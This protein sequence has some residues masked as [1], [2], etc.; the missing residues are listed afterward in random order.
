MSLSTGKPLRRPR[1]LVV[2]R[3]RMV[4]EG[5]KFDWMDMGLVSGVKD[6]GC[7]LRRSQNLGGGGRTWRWAQCKNRS[8]DRDSGSRW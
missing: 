1:W 5:R 6:K 7:M 8:K 2:W 3:V 4:V